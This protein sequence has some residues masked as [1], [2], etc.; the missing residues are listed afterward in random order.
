MFLFQ[1][2]QCACG[3]HH[4]VDPARRWCLH[5]LYRRLHHQQRPSEERRCPG[6][7]RPTDNRQNAPKTPR[8]IGHR[9]LRRVSAHASL[10]YQWDHP[11][12]R[13]KCC[14]LFDFLGDRNSVGMLQEPGTQVCRV[15]SVS[16]SVHWSTHSGATSVPVPVFPGLPP[17]HRVFTQV[18]R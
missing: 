5:R 1:I 4:P 2:G 13:S 12:V 9:V 6:D 11:A 18:R 14:L 8:V 7:L 10:V 15:Q 17:S 16:V 3:W